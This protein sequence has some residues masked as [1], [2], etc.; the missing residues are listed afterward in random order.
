MEANANQLLFRWESVAPSCEAVRYLINASNCGHFPN[1]TVTCTGFSLDMYNQ[2]EVC[3]L[4][5]LTVVC[6]N[7]TGNESRSVQVTLRGMSHNLL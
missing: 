2:L 3:V 6:D 7:I 5:V 4:S 1:T